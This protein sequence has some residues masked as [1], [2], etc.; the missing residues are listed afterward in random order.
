MLNSVTGLASTSSEERLVVVKYWALLLVGIITAIYHI[1]FAYTYALQMNLHLV[2]SLGLMMCVA[3]IYSFN[4]RISRDDGLLTVLDNYGLIPVELVAA[5]VASVYMYTNYQRL[6]IESLGIF[7]DI[8]IL[9]GFILLF[10]VFDLSRRTFGWVLVLVGFFGIFYALTASYWPGIFQSSSLDLRSLIAALTVQFSGLYDII[11]EVAAT[12]ILIYILFAGFLEAYGALE[13]FIRLGARVGKR[14]KSGITQTAVISSLGMGSVNG[15]AAANAATTGALT[16]PLMKEQGIKKDTAAAVEAVASSGG[17]IMP[18]IMGASAFLMAEITG[19]SY[20]HVITIGLFPA[21]LFYFTVAT[22]VYFI[23]DKEGANAEAIFEGDIDQPS[24]SD[25]SRA[26]TD[27][28]LNE[29]SI[30]SSNKIN[31]ADITQA[32]KESSSILNT[33]IRGIYLWFPVGVLVYTLVFLRYGALYAG[34][35]AIGAA[36]V[37]GLFHKMYFADEYRKAFVEFVADTA[38]GM[39]LGSQNAAGIAMAAALMGLFVEVLSVTGFTTTLTQQLVALSGGMLLLLLP[40][41][42]LAAILFGLGMPTTGAYIVAVL[43]IAPALTDLGVRVETAHLYVLYFAVLSALTPPVAIANIITAEI[44]GANFFR[45]CYK[46]VLIGIPLFILPYLFVINPDILYWE[47]PL[48]AI[49]FV[50]LFVSLLA[51]S[52]ASIDYFFGSLSLVQRV[53]LVV[54]SVVASLG[55]ALPLPNMQLYG[56]RVTAFAVILAI[57][58]LQIFRNRAVSPIGEKA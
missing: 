10:L 36:I 14:M 22:A 15:S 47:F 52:A 17:Q 2:I 54:C 28:W 33:L 20:L 56:L 42:M 25:A 3:A 53:V 50:I 46:S 23:T 8:D 31:L 49:N 24:D 27:D 51:L 32:T 9:V 4:P 18:P 43:L 55:T 57:F 29:V 34:V 38:E 12:Y 5:V 6:Y 16:I 37:S 41:A 35:L 19:T 7:T 26:D 11:F 48:T 21:L 45:T 13:Y 40:L 44:S 30:G 39:R 58:F 1:W